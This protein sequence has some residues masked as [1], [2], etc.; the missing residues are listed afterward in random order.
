MEHVEEGWPM[1]KQLKAFIRRLYGNYMTIQQRRALKELPT[2]AVQAR[3][4]RAPR[5]QRPVD[6]NRPRR[7]INKDMDRRYALPL[8]ILAAMINGRRDLYWRRDLFL[9]TLVF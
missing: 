7:T 2:K 6:P 3:P 9:L 5:P 4:P 1:R 8:A